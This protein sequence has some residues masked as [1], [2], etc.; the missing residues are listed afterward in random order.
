MG[1]HLAGFEV[2]GVDIMPQPNYPFEFHEADAL[3]YPLENFDV[4]HAS[5]PC[6][7][8]SITAR[9]WPDKKYS[10][11]LT[12]TRERLQTTDKIWVIENVPGAPMDC[13][14]AL[15]GLMFD[16]KVFRHRFFELSHLVFQPNHVPH[17]GK[18]IG[19]GY[20]CVTGH[21]GVW[22]NWNRT[23][24][25]GSNHSKHWPEAMGID[26]MTRYELTQA[27]PPAY[28]EYIGKQLRGFFS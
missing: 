14:I 12:P 27:I 17:N 13:T 19:K 1:Y 9:R 11:L 23:K 21:G 7:K 4:I 3:T 10:D 16:L 25:I 26:F 28:T 5:P 18:R 2:V 20:F 15:C 22:K 8:F 24:K 6:Q